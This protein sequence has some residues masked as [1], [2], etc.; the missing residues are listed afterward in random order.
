[1]YVYI[2]WQGQKAVLTI[3]EFEFVGRFCVENSAS[4]LW[5]ELQMSNM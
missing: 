4:L 5:P 3:I 1:M 2:L